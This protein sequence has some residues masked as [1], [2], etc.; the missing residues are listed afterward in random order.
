MVAALWIAWCLYWPFF[1]RKQD[2]HRAFKEADQDYRVCLQEHIARSSDCLEDRDLSRKRLQHAVAPPEEN[3]YQRF[4]GR[5]FGDA[6]TFM[7]TLALLP[8]LLLYALA[9]LAMQG[10][11]LKTRDLRRV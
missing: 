7:A 4:A 2:I 9:R 1:A 10:V 6:L 5:N 11:R 3:A 8:P